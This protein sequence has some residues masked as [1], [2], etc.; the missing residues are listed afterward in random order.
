[1]VGQENF[2]NRAPQTT[3]WEVWREETAEEWDLVI[4]CMNP[5]KTRANP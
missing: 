5:H 2:K 1:M 3:V 4:M